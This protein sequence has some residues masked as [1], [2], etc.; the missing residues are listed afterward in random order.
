MYLVEYN[1]V[2]KMN[3]KPKKQESMEMEILRFYDD[4]EQLSKALRNVPGQTRR[5]S[6]ELFFLWRLWTN[7]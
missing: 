7:R 4:I 2:D 5:I 1:G 6:P 3:E